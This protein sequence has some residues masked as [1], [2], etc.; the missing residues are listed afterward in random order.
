MPALLLLLPLLLLGSD[1]VAAGAPPPAAPAPT[2]PAGNAGPGQSA[3]VVRVYF[4]SPAERDRLATTLDALEVPTT[5]GYLTV[6]S[7][8]AGMDSLRRQGLRVEVDA[9]LTASLNTPVTF[10]NSADNFFGGYHTV[11]EMGQFLD[12]EAAAYPNLAEK[13]D[14]GD[15]WCKAHPGQCV[16]PDPYNGYDMLALHITNRSIPGPKPVFWVEAGIHAREISPPEVALDYIAYLLD[17]Y[18]TNADAH[19]LVDWTDIY[20]IPTLN[21]DGHHIVEAG[22]GGLNPYYQRKN[23]NDTNGCLTWPPEIGNQF[24][25]DLNRNFPFLWNCCG[26]SSDVPCAEAYH[27]TAAASEDE[28][29]ATIAEIRALIPDQRGP[30]ITDPAPITT[31]GT[32]LD[33][34]S[35]SDVNLYPWAMYST[36]APNEADLTNLAFHL[37]STNAEPPGDDYTPCQFGSCLYIADGVTNDWVYGELGAAAFAEEIGDDFFTPYTTTQTIL[38]PQN[39]G[40]MLY[41]AKVARMPYLLTRGPDATLVQSDPLTVTQGISANLTAT[42]N[43]A[44]N[45]HDGYDSYLQNVAA[46]EYYVDTPP[47]AGGTPLPLLPADGQFNSPTEAVAALVSTGSLS[48]GRHILFVRGRGVNEYDGYHSWGPVSA[49]WLTVQPYASPT[50]TATGTPPTATATRTPIPTSTPTSTPCAAPVIQN[51]GFETGSLS[52]GWTILDANPTPVVSALHTHAGGFSAFLGSVPNNE[53]YGDS[54]IYQQFTVPASGGTLSFWY[55][56]YSRDNIQFDWQ[57]AYLTDGHGAILATIMHVLQGTETW[58]NVTYPL[59]AYAG[60]TVRVEFLVHQDGAGD[61]AHMYVDDVMLLEAC[62]TAVPATPSATA[63]PSSTLTPL[64]PTGTPAE[65][66][67]TPAPPSATPIPPSGTPL[68]PSATACPVTFSDVD[69]TD[70]FYVPVQYLSCHGVISGYADGTFRPYHNTTR[71]Q[72]VKIVVLGFGLPITTPAAGHYTFADVRADFPFFD[73]IETAAAATV[74]SG[75]TC[76]GPGEPCDPQNRP[77]FRPY[78]NVTRG[79]LSK[80]DVVA[81]NWSLIAPPDATFEDVLPGSAFYRFVETAVEHGVLSGYTCGGPGE[82]CDPQNRPYFR[83]GNDATRGQIAKIVY[84]S[85]TAGGG[86]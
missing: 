61:V 34:H 60:Q 11:E 62:P 58:T 69:E 53:P 78:N 15:S 20:V 42:I 59:D 30:D 82:P 84:L 80:I 46:A 2:S 71:A 5:G 66:S 76:G 45:Y 10:G 70:Y 40:M 36:P 63:P 1:L 77:Y 86:Q 85:I 64:P 47:W 39:R 22:G 37:A 43:Y 52:P 73:V 29:Q 65:A 44:W 9:H 51:G 57:D 14:F 81:A 6:V 79:Q 13:V 3:L 26:G 19:W 56:P 12:Q 24:G 21:P 75:Y 25:T 31:T 55:F 38:W 27:G 74:V 68:P 49:T 54:S 18:A 33:M 50:P 35:F 4:R 7:D 83:Q 28:T 67:P 41:L 16:Q 23:A 17:N 72:M 48:V 8:A 32:F